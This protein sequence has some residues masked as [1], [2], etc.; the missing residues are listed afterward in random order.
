[1]QIIQ[2]P[3][4]NRRYEKAF[5][6]FPY[7]LYRN[8]AQWVPPLKMEMHNIFKPSHPFYEYGQASFFLAVTGTGEVLGR[9]AVAN[10]HRYNKFHRTKTGFFYYFECIDDLSVARA[11]FSRGFEW[12][13]QQGLNHILGPKGFTVLDGF[14]LLVEG[15][16]HRSA[17]G[18]AYNPAHYPK[19]IES[20]GFTKLKD[21]YTGWIDRNSQISEKVFKAAKIVE[22]RMG[23]TA[24]NINTKRELRAVVDDFKKM[25]NDTLAVPAGNPPISDEDMDNIVRQLLWI[26]DPKLV[27]LIYKDTRPIGWILAYPDIGAALQRIRGHL[28]PLGWLT[29]LRERKKSDRINFNGI[30]IIKDY[31][32]LGGTA[33]LYN[34]IFKNV[35]NYDQYHY[36]EL[37]QLRE[38]NIN[39]LLETE[40]MDI[41]F[42]KT[43]RLYEKYL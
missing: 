33:I 31:Q 36:A 22:K 6:D 19:F 16:E 41:N 2:I 37:L 28:F 8:N 1:M 17:F 42:H 38:E 21:V 10:N 15:F 30:G 23:F 43:H 26:A 32:G 25:Y 13:Q 35:M 9:L 24:P 12:C 14:G 27:R 3:P 11:L 40:N 5:I 7:Q 18:Q 20:V 29:I 34:E 4:R 39:I